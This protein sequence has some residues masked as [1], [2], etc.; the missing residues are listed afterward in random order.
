ME[1]TSDHNSVWEYLAQ[2]NIVYDAFGTF[3]VVSLHSFPHVHLKKKMVEMGQHD[4]CFSLL[5]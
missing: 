5:F 4:Y 3:S 1:K 2:R